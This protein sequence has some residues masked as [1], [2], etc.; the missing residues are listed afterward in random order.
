MSIFLAVKVS[1]DSYICL[2]KAWWFLASKITCAR[3]EILVL[4][5]CY[6]FAY[7]C[8]TKQ[9]NDVIIQLRGFDKLVSSSTIFTFTRP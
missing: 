6:V 8:D 3:P 5:F 9:D 2:T 4:I 1:K 7:L